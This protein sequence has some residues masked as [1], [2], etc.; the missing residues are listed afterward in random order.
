[1]KMVE[2]TQERDNYFYRVNFPK[3][4]KTDIFIRKF[5][6]IMKTETCSIGS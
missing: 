1:M 5:E 6:R 4:Y 2:V 3:E